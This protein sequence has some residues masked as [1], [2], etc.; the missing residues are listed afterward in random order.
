MKSTNWQKTKV[1]AAVTAAV[2]SIMTTGHAVAQEEIEEVV[3]T[4]IRSSLTQSMDVKRFSSGVVDAISAEDIGQFPDT[5]LAESLQRITGVSID[6]VN[7]EGSE[8]TVRGFGGGFNLVT[9]NGRQLPASNV[10][11]VNGNSDAAGATGNSRSFDFSNLASE[12]VSGIQVYKTG[13]ANVPTGG[14]GATINIQTV[15]PLDSGNQLVIGAKAMHDE[16]GEES[17]TPEL[18]GLWSWTNDAN[19][20]GISAFGS[21]Q[22]RSSGSR[23]VNVSVYSFFDY[24]P[25]LSFLQNATVVNPP[26]VGALM[27]LPANI[28]MN[29]AEIERE[30]TNAML[31]MQWAPSDRTTITGDLLYTSNSLAQANI[32]P[33]IWYSRQFSYIEFDGSP[34]VATP[35]R[36]I[37]NIA[38]PDGRGKDYFFASWDQAVKDEML[39]LGIN[40]EHAF[41]DDWTLTVDAATSDS[42]S[43]GDAGDGKSTWR[44]NVA[45][46]G[47]GWQAADYTGGVP[48]ATIGVVENSG[49]AGGNGNGIL[50]PE[51]IATQTLTTVASNQDTD[52]DQ[53]NLGMEWNIDDGA[54][55][56]FGVGYLKTEM[57]QTNLNTT[58][59][60]GG[61]GRRRQGHSG[62][63]QHADPGQRTVAVQ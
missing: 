5:N 12:G 2:C 49:P 47:A 18:S 39:T 52:I 60:L 61:W 17:I 54:N 50:D 24:D 19:T 63:E 37:E 53:F 13:R 22:E 30:R 25:G 31:T 55:V 48:T 16:S 51:D 29:L 32:V 28:G 44:F 38:P 41:N 45:A 21:Y 36:L 42:E 7:G 1:S 9:L 43:G 56:Q 4:A 57:A 6:R 59:F 46:A 23:G 33:G 58:D 40:L 3:V 10:A 14:V 15:R 11:S 8:V 35:I 62:S 26:P 27:A 34:I 20:F